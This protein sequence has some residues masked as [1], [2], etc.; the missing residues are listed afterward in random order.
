MSLFLRRS[1]D[2]FTRRLEE[3]ISLGILI[4]NSLVRDRYGFWLR[5]GVHSTLNLSY[6]HNQSISLAPLSADPASA[7]EA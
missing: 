4:C 1:D 6:I 7:S 5:L 3:V 2:F